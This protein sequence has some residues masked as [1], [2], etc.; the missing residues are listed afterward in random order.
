VAFGRE[1]AALTGKP[2][3]YVDERLSSFEAE[4]A[5]VTRKRAGEKMTRKQKKSRLDALAAVSFLSEF[6]AG[7]L[8]AIDV[9]RMEN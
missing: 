3:I 4:Q 2:V 7:K 9:E 1:L 8:E 6:L 5:L